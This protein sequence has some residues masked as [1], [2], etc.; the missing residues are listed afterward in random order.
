[1]IGKT[2]GHYLIISKIGAGGMGEVYIARDKRLERDVA[3]KILPADALA[4]DAARKRFRKEALALSKLNHPNIATIFDF[5]TE[6]GVDFLAMEYVHGETLAQKLSGGSLP[7]K[8]TAAIAVQIVDSLEEAHEQGIVHRDLKPSNIMVT[9]KGRVKVLDFG[10]AK[11]LRPV[12]SIT[13]AETL[14]ETQ[15]LAGTLPYMS[16]EQ[17]QDEQVDARSD[18]FSFGAVVYESATGQRPFRDEVVSRLMDA[19][20]HQ[21]SVPARALNPRISPELERI[22]LKCLEKDPALR[23]QSAKDVSVD[24]R[25]L[26]SSSRLASPAR[27][28][29]QR[30]WLR[31]PLVMAGSA[32]IVVILIVAILVALNAGGWR[33]QLL[34]RAESSRAINSLAVLPL[35]NVPHDPNQEYFADGMTEALITDLGQIGALSV[36][37][38]TSAMR[39]KG[40]NKSIPE[41]ARELHVDAVLIG[42]IRRTGD[43]VRV[44]AQLVDGT[45]DMNLWAKNFDRDLRDILPLQ[46]EVAQDIA[47]GIQVRVT[48]QEKTRLSS[49]RPVS[50]EAHEAYLRGLFFFN[51]ARET[52]QNTALQ[53]N[54]RVQPFQQSIEYFQRAIQLQP[55]YA[56]AYAALARAYHWYAG[57]GG[58]AFYAKSLEASRKALQIDDS[59]SEAHGALA[60]VLFVSEWD[61]AG[62]EK[63]LKRSL[64]L[65]PGSGEVHHIYALFHL[66]LGR[67]D[68]AIREIARAIELDPL[69]TT[70]KWNEVLMY[71]CAGQYDRAIDKVRKIPEVD[72]NSPL[73]HLEI[74]KLEIQKGMVAEGLAEIQKSSTM[75]GTDA[76]GKSVKYWLA[77]A[78]AVSGKK[79]EATKVLDELKELSTKDPNQRMWPLGIANIY[80]AL[81]DKDAALSWLENGFQQRSLTYIKCSHSARILKSDPR[82][83]DLLRRMGLPQ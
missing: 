4:D 19:I 43:K 14:S 18:I 27:S 82:F 72:P 40:T 76:Q 44:S 7:E 6:S 46:D 45:T 25:R 2:L 67:P 34:G 15:G 54:Q 65:N 30:K 48:P 29:P 62:T 11:L 70:Q 47:N 12:G 23:Y 13:T 78:Y 56:A 61:W 38:R 37:S 64:E 22:I 52:M 80:S 28:E 58:A 24:I 9:P 74:G 1:M 68:E 20:M 83:Q 36:I 5:D 51:E 32:I 26:D 49:F 8:E 81:G 31:S 55:D 75:A 39:Y 17:L 50:P 16:P 3:L 69:T 57:L 21:P 79:D 42:T 35:E 63:E 60:Y 33:D 71:A 77:W 41:I 59:N 66:A 53:F 10:L 73:K